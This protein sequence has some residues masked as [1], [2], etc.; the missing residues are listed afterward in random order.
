MIVSTTSKILIGLFCALG[1]CTYKSATLS[2]VAKEEVS[3]SEALNI[4]EKED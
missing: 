3:N 4:T 2:A 1:Y